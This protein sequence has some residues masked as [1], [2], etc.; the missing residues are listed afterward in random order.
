MPLTAPVC[1]LP[2]RDLQPLIDDIYCLGLA[3]TAEGECA[4][5]KGSQKAAPAPVPEIP[6]ELPKLA[7]EIQNDNAH[8]EDR[9]QAKVCI[10]W[11]HWALKEY[12]LALAALPGNYDEENPQL[13]EFDGLREWTKVCGLKGAYLKANC[14][15]R[16][17]RRAGALKAFES[18]LHSLS[19]VW[20][21]GNARQ[22]LRYWA[23]LF[24]TEY[25]MLAGQ[26]VRE[27][28]TVLSDPNCLAPFRTWS[29]YWAGT[30]GSPLPGGFGFR[31]AVP[32][33]R[34]WSE[35]YHVLS[36]ILQRDLPYPTGYAAV[37]NESS[38]RNHLRAELKKVE[39]IY[40]GLLYSETRFPKA[41][42]ER[43]EVEEFVDQVM[44]NWTIL[45]GRGWREQDL[46]A[47]GRDSLSHGVLDTLYGAAMKTYH[48]TA[49]LRHLFAVH[50]ALAEFD[51]AFIS[52]NSYFALIKKGRARV[53]KTGHDEPALDSN[54]TMLE[55]V[56]S[57]V[58]A[59]C[60]Y[61]G[62]E[63]ADKARALAIE[64]EELVQELTQTN[65]STEPNPRPCPPPHS[66][67][68]AWQAIGLAHAQWARMTYDSEARVV[69]QDKAISCLRKSMSPEYG[70]A[71][72][73]RGVF[74]LAVLLAEQ[75]KLSVA[76]ELVK[77]ALLADKADEENQELYHGPYWRERSL[78]PLWHLL[79][80]LLSARQEYTM[81]ARACEGAIEQFKDP[82]VLFGG[83]NLNG[84]YRSD[85]LNDVAVERTGSDGLVDEMDD[86][87]KESILE[88]KMTQLAILEL[89]EGPAVAVNASTELLTLFPRL[90]GDLEPKPESSAKLEPPKTS[91][92]LRSIRG[93]VF[94]SRSERSSRPRQ[95]VMTTNEKMETIP[96]RPATTQTA[97]SIATTAPTIH[98]THENGDSH[99]TRNARRSESVKGR[100]ESATRRTSLR[101]RS[102]SS[103]PRASSS[104]GMHPPTIVDGDR[105]FTPFND[106]QG[107]HYFAFASQ[108][109]E[110]T[111]LTTLKHSNSQTSSVTSESTEAESDLSAVVVK[112][113]ET[114][115]SKLPY[116]QFSQEHTKR[117]R[118]AMLVAVWLAIGGFYRRAGL[119]GDAQKAYTEAN[120]IVEKLEA[121]VSSDSS[122]S[123]SA[124]QTGW[125]QRKSID[126]L[127]ADVWAEVNYLHLYH[128][129][130]Q[131]L[132]NT[133]KG[134][135]SVARERPYNAQADFETAL[136]HFPDHGPAIV[137]LSNILMD[138]YSEKL[139]PPP[140]V[141]GLD[142]IAAA[143]DTSAPPGP[144]TKSKLD[145][146]PLLPS[147]PLGMG[148]SGGGRR[149]PSKPKKTQHEPF[150]TSTTP[151]L[152][153]AARDNKPVPEP[154]SITELPPPH[155]A[156]SRPLLDRLAAR[157]RAY[158]LLSGL[159]KLGAGWNYS[160]AWFAL[161]R[162]YE[163]SDQPDKARDALWWCVELEDARGAR[164]WS[165][166]G[167]GGGYVL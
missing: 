136:T 74:A 137:G 26:A 36:E 94:G 89:V 8:H 87:E 144:T 146:Y 3:A 83:K 18:A 64:L 68:V 108:K 165:C 11:M 39:T 134:N 78:I 103:R 148:T 98:V 116:V 25:C 2:R 9:F 75:R 84:G 119:L 124:R 10:G 150:K 27:K 22:Q 65:G 152:D 38:A 123:V 107:A 49:V 109:T 164:D 114:F 50:L 70:Q 72:D 85:H 69:F 126:E 92:T 113:V 131:M 59:L 147:A 67:S 40:Q 42:E 76:I 120:Q 1:S 106:L 157:D 63:A 115:G 58:A 100:G 35:Y 60:R 140:A 145:N 62:R 167:A 128:S 141:G 33:R 122:G 139:L 48:S 14:L 166:V 41:N 143:Q 112:A 31:G 118:R 158:M 56:S 93:S 117:R 30:K 110:T 160:E 20:G 55:T 23:E 16:E 47:G 44:R 138:I 6:R 135:L 99:S 34:V 86:Y 73:V 29:K 5:T 111:G 133:Q 32:R 24:L 162:A 66:F 121:D 57:C 102:S 130:S 155:K 163:E 156:T 82:T 151:F 4:I 7:A 21:T 88:I 17:G 13:D 61:G 142:V 46:G 127:L 51:L 53:M 80:L 54:A 81:A 95:S 71:A 104:G 161:A 28:E 125:G 149:G 79:A 12:D 153:H 132:T 101:K 97:Q 19:G 45:N 91:A 37:N 96:S 105:F 159:T 77:T 90:F 154:T 129:D 43:A 52:F 15:A